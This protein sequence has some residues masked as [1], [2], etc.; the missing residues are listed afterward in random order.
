MNNR[1]VPLVVALFGLGSQGL[2]LAQGRDSV[3]STVDLLIEKCWSDLQLDARYSPQN[4]IALL[5][6]NGAPLFNIAVAD[7]P[8]FQKK[9]N[10]DLGDLPSVVGPERAAGIKACMAPY[11]EAANKGM[12]A[13]V[14]VAAPSAVVPVASVEPLPV[15][16]QSMGIVEP[17]PGSL[18][19]IVHN[20]SLINEAT[21]SPEPSRVNRLLTFHF[22]VEARATNETQGIIN[23]TLFRQ[24]KDVCTIS[25]NT[26]TSP[27]HDGVR[28]GN[29]ICNDTVPA[30][31]NVQYR[32]RVQA[33]EMLPIKILLAYVDAVRK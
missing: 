7:I 29:A 20:A 24:G 32:T 18:G 26:K 21:W 16:V 23:M 17:E 15:P 10:K 3:K 33:A 22:E 25:L 1:I 9:L 4:G 8:A 27:N 31:A 30:N 5:G 2:V 12:A 11:V 14:P 28:W 6:S 19:R 13:P